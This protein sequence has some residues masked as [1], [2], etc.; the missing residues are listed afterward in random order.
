MS[1]Q[2]YTNKR[3]ILV[4][5]SVLKVQYPD[6]AAFTNRLVPVINC[7]QL[8]QPIVY[9]DICRC[10]FNG[11]GTTHKNVFPSIFDGGNSNTVNIEYFLSG[12]NNSTN[13]PQ[14]FSGGSS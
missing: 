9:K 14:I 11:Y 12:G 7:L 10:P 3:R 2:S 13:S 5:A 8:V 1:A 4:E 6:N